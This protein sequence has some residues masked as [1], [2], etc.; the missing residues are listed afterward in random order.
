MGKQGTTPDTAISS[1]SFRA[2]SLVLLALFI[3]PVASAFEWHGRV[4]DSGTNQLLANVSINV[5]IMAISK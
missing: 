4:K 5:S 1:V 3:V 2:L